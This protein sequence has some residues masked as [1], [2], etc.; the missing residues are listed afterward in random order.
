LHGEGSVRGGIY[1]WTDRDAY[2][3]FLDSG[4][5]QAWSV[6]PNIADLQK[7]DYGVDE[8][9]TRVTRGLMAAVG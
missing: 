1:V 2:R 3:A 9:P 5:S 7:R 4:L 8:A 6:H